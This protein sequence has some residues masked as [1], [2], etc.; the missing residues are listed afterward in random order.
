[1]KVIFT[2]GCFDILHVGHVKRLYQAKSFGDYL[3]VGLNSDR[4]VRQ[5][6]GENRPILNQDDRMKMLKALEVVDEVVIFDED[7][8]ANLI[9]R[10]RPDVL[11]QGEDHKDYVSGADFVKS[12]GGKVVLL[13][14]EEGYSTTKIIERIKVL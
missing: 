2:N 6:K 11:V 3:V 14:L 9:K 12:C 5:L 1:M 7:E 10:I 8:P 13:P 4:S